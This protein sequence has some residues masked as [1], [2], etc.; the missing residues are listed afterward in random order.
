M[1][2]NALLELSDQVHLL[3]LRCTIQMECAGELDIN[4]GSTFHGGLGWALNEVAPHLW[5]LGYGP[6]EQRA[7]RPFVITPPTDTQHWQAGGSLQFDLTLFGKMA[8][9]LSSI[10]AALNHWGERGLGKQ[11]IRFNLT[12]VMLL[13]HAGESLLWLKTHKQLSPAIH[14][15][16]GHALLSSAELWAQL[17][18]HALLI[19]IHSKTRLHL[20]E[21]GTVI[22]QA[23]SALAL[24]K[25]IARR[26]MQ[27]APDMNDM[28]RSAIFNNLNGLEKTWLSWDQTQYLALHRFS[29]KEQR[30]HQI[31]GVVGRWGYEGPGT[32][33][34]LPWLAIGRWLHV[35][36]KT[37]FGFGAIRWQFGIISQN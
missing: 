22:T 12:Q 19:Q 17:S 5:H 28:Q 18:P 11:R 10:L 1:S 37:S 31:D 7:I 29:A 15:T 23:P 26:I 36:N 33:A 2:I 25:G 9:D 4:A 21:N 6:I 30:Y 20:K 8:T 3:P 13:S 34:L 27:L 24:A 35:G 16:L 32:A 14:M